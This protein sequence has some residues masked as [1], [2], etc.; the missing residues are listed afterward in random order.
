MP[1][2]WGLTGGVDEQHVGHQKQLLAGF[3]RGSEALRAQAVS[4]ERGPPPFER[5]RVPLRA[6]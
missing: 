5:S 2:L 3:L 1:P 6:R 4:W